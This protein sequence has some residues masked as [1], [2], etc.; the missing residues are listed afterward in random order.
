VTV[1][2][3]EDQVEDSIQQYGLGR[4]KLDAAARRLGDRPYSFPFL[5][6][7]EAQL[8]PQSC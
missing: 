3:S 8:P 1:G 6:H 2:L 7:D 5:G 4:G